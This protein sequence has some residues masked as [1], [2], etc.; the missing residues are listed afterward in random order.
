MKSVAL[1][2]FLT[3]ISKAI[4]G[5]LVNIENQRIQSDS[6]RRVTIFDLR[7]N[8]QKNNNEVLS[9]INFS[10][11]NQYKSK[12]FKNYYL[13]IGNIDYAISNSNELSNSG[14]VHFRYNRKINSKLRIEAFTQYQYNKILGIEMRNLIGAGP[15]YKI[16]KSEK[17][18]FY[19]GSLFMQ[20]FERTIDNNKIMSFQRL[21]N[22]LSF[23]LKNSIKSIEISS[24][25][26]Y[27][28]NINLWAD[29]RLNS[30]TSV[31]FNITSKLQFVNSINLGY[32]SY[33]P[34]NISKKNTNISNGLKVNL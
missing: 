6:V 19:A 24:V 10:A 22:Y 16:N 18:V 28:P 34:S 7:Y 26:Y 1:I 4:N 12:N 3:I 14:L 20:E 2:L 23:S 30:L 27:Q 31:V 8:Y 29:Y 13:I 25:L 17:I 15:R 32:D 11:T 9:Q 21:S 33:V 5:Q